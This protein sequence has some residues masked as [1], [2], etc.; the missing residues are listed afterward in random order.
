VKLRALM[1]SWSRGQSSAYRRGGSPH[2]A[3]ST[4]AEGIFFLFLKCHHVESIA[5]GT[6]RNVPGPKIVGYC[7][8]HER[9]SL[10]R[11]IFSIGWL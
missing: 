3:E 9:E 1:F 5:M 11:F 8:T 10:M 2:M 7:T 6:G 4:G